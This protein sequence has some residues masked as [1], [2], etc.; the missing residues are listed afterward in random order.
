MFGSS[1]KKKIDAVIEY[2]TGILKVQ[3]ADYSDNAVDDLFLLG[4]M[5]GVIDCALQRL[6]IE[7]DIEGIGSMTSVCMRL[8]G[9]DEGAKVVGRMLAHVKRMADFP[10]FVSGLTMGGNEANDIFNAWA[11][12]TEPP[13]GLGLLEHL[14][15]NHLHEN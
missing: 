14:R 8:F 7:D 15:S 12:K 10:E 6:G 2:A 5:Y 13:I 1:K 4:Y 11:E 9:K 3:L